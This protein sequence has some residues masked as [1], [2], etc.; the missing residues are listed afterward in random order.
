MLYRL[1]T[2][3]FACSSLLQVTQVSAAEYHLDRV[4]IE[5]VSVVQLAVGNLSGHK[6]GNLEVKI[7]GGFTLPAGF[8]C[9]DR[10]YLTTLKSVDA[11]KRMFALLTAAQTAKQPVSLWI[12]DDPTYTA[13]GGRCSLLAV[14]LKPS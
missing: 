3:I 14:S 13:A 5:D 7:Q 6:S 4:F 1:I 10:I 12:T 9:F 11:D 8:G 2:T